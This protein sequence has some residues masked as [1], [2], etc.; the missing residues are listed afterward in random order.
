MVRSGLFFVSV[1]SAAAFWAPAA[2]AD[3][4]IGVAGPMTGAYA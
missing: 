3:T 4:R 1:I 2:Q